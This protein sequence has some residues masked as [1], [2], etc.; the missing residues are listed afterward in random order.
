MTSVER[1]RFVVPGRVLFAAWVIPTIAAS[2]VAIQPRADDL[3]VVL[4]LGTM[5]FATAAVGLSVAMRIG[6]PMRR[7]VMGRPYDM[8]F[9]AAMA[10]ACAWG[11]LSGLFLGLTM[12]DTAIDS[13]FLWIIVFAWIGLGCQMLALLGFARHRRLSARALS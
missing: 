6:I 11:P 2:F 4:T 10:W 5:A 13:L 12:A 9:W 3:A 1:S 7:T 8:W